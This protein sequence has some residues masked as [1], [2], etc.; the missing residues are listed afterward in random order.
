MSGPIWQARYYD[1][2]VFSQ[3][4]INEKL[5]YIHNNPVKAGL[6]AKVEDWKHDSSRWYLF[7]KQVGIE[8]AGFWLTSCAKHTDSSYLCHPVPSI[9]RPPAPSDADGKRPIGATRAHKGPTERLI[10]LLENSDPLVA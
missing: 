4:M 6:V 9:S 5:E 8:I 1:F 10:R 7:G 3:K 2:S